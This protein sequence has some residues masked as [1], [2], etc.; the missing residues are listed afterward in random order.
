MLSY[1][2]SFHAGN[3]ADV[4]KHII[5]VE[6]LKELRKDG[7]AFHYI[8]THAGVGTYDLHSGHA[9]KTGEYL[10]GIARL[11]RQDWPELKDY[12][13][14]VY[15]FNKKGDIRFYPG[16]PLIAQQF[17]RPLDKATLFELH[18]TDVKR[19]KRQFV[20]DQRIE[21][22]HKDG[23]TGLLKLLSQP[24]QRGL[25]L[26]DPPYEIKSDYERVVQILTEAY[27]Q[28]SQGT[29]LLWYPV[30]ERSRIDKM[31]ADLGATNFRRLDRY[32]LAVAP[33]TEGRGMTA[34]GVFVINGS[35]QM[36][37]QFEPNLLKL[38]AT[39]GDQSSEK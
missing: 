15:Q 31:A 11:K 4:L 28:F 8:D 17:M 10:N 13:D 20:S 26:I 35:N 32:E 6:C 34:A 21:V 37:A 25:V 23:F 9:E 24:I 33:D 14:T 27:E 7:R 1:R 36:K 12:L 2:H 3:Y 29:Y 39:L 16:S 19:L 5:L 30:V 18:S 38:R 22:R